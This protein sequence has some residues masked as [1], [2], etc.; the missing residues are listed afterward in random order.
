[1]KAATENAEEL[2]VK[3]SRIMNRA[4][5]ESI[6]TE[7]MEIVG[8]AESLEADPWGSVAH[9]EEIGDALVV[10]FGLHAARHPAVGPDEARVG[11]GVERPRELVEEAVGVLRADGRRDLALVDGG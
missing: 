3:L 11:V 10:V 5:Q 8:G 6:T 4:R 1:M 7:I 9:G 2:I